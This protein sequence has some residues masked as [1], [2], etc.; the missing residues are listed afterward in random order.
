MV[1]EILKIMA[2]LLDDK[3]SEEEIKKSILTVEN[4]AETSP[5]ISDVF[6]VVNCL[7]SD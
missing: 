2:G 5:V 6:N 7:Y 1:C 4:I 3:F